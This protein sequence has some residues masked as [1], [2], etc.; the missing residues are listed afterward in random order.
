VK[1]TP[2]IEGFDTV[3]IELERLVINGAN[4]VFCGTREFIQNGARVRVLFGLGEDES[5]ELLAAE[6][7]L[8]IEKS[9]IE[10]LV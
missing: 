3:L 7:A 5:G 2:K 8:A 9:A 1:V 4:E 10:V 6:A